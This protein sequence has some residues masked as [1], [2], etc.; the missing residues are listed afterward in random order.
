MDSQELERHLEASCEMQGL[1]FKES[2]EWKTDTFAKDILALSNVQDGGYIIVGVR[3][4]NNTFERTGI[5]PEHKTTFDVDTMKDQ[6]SSFADPNVNFS[7]EFIKDRAG[8][9]FVVITVFSFKTVPVICSKDTRDTHRGKIYYRNTN[10]RVESAPVSNSHD[11][12]H[13]IEIATVRK[14]QHWSGL[15]LSVNKSIKEKLEEELQGL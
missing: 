8:L 12:Q 1:D 3:E 11:L 13:I 14:M 6:M 7:V 9:E 4:S 2:C 5:T 10:R 15:G